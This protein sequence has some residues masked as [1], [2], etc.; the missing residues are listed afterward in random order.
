MAIKLELALL[1]NLEIRQGGV[2]MTDFKSSKAQALLSYLAVTGQPHTRTAL[3]GLLWGGMPERKARMNLSQALTKLRRMF[4]KHLIIT[5]QTVAFKH[6]S[7]YWLDVEAFE[8][9]P[10]EENI[11][12]LQEA[13]QLYRGIFWMVSM[14]EKLPNSKSGY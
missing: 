9:A 7:D 4:G 2:P 5:R 13:V 3:A 10:A 6:D 1:G 8:T 12:S 14:C 11:E